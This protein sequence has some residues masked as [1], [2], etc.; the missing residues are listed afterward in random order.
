MSDDKTDLSDE[1][2]KLQ[3]EAEL[4]RH[5]KRFEAASRQGLDAI[6]GNLSPMT[7]VKEFP[8]ETA[9]LGFLGGLFLGI[10]KPL[11]RRKG[12]SLPY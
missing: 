4:E 3:L 5:K 2:R 9:L 6:R 1:A 8:L 10:A 11:D 12:R 7:W